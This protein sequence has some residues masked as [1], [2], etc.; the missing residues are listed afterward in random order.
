MSE[1]RIL[2]SCILRHF[3]VDIP[4]GSELANVK[5]EAGN[6]VY[7]NWTRNIGGPTQPHSLKL[8]ITPLSPSLSKM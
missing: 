8:N 4:V 1:M 5:P 6:V 7:G 2:L 3:E